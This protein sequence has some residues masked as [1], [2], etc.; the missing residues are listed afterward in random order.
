[1]PRRLTSATSV[2]LPAVLGMTLLGPMVAYAQPTK[3]KPKPTV[4]QLQKE[5]RERDTLIR[6][7]VRRVENLERRMTTD[8]SASA[9]PTTAMK[10]S[11]RARATAP[12][13]P[14]TEIAALDPEESEPAPATPAKKP[15]PARVG[16][17][18]KAVHTDPPAPGQFEVSEETAQRALE[19]TLVAT[20]NLLVP[21][22]FAEVEP[23]FGYTRRE[24]SALGQ[25]NVPVL[26]N[27][28][29]NE[30]NWTLGARLGLPWESQFEIALPY[31]LVQH[32]I[33]D[34]NV[35]P[36]QQVSYRSANAVGDVTIGLAKTLV[37]ESGW[38]PDLLGRITYEAPTGPLTTNQVP[39]TS[40][41]SKLSFAGTALKRQDP[42]V[43]TGTAGYTKAFEANHVSPGDQ[44]NFQAGA[45]L[46]TSPETTLRGVLQQNFIQDTTVNNVTFKGSNSAQSI[47][48]FGASSILG[49]GILADLQVGIGLTNSAPKYSIILSST[50]RFGVPG[51]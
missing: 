27:L 46:G 37:H 19:R 22:G 4:E 9:S 35:S 29:R 42:L 15:A 34:A 39:M 12:S 7:L 8:A 30:F 23:L 47:L 25:A 16:A 1:M 17:A 21:S 2:A 40:G 24:L 36:P 33:T 51:L 45:F 43:F 32:Q 48:N 26:F 6:S 38:I 41:Q 44:I 10:R 28:N 13:S 49:R 20:G 50:Y 18:Q 14:E 3:P 31:N 5:L 11:M